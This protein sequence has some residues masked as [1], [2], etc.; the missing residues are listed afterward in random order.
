VICAGAAKADACDYWMPA[1]A[2]MTVNP[3]FHFKKLPNDCPVDAS[4]QRNDCIG[5]GLNQELRS[6]LKLQAAR[7]YTYRRKHVRA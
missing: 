1:F 4:M 5:A 6:S 7:H 2:G 3:Q